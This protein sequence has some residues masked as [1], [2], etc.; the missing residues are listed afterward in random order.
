MLDPLKSQCEVTVNRQCPVCPTTWCLSH[1][2]GLKLLSAFTGMNVICSLMFLLLQVPFSLWSP[3]R[4]GV[5]VTVGD[6]C[7]PR[8]AFM[9]CC[10]PLHHCLCALQGVSGISS[11]VQA[12]VCPCGT[13]ISANSHKLPNRSLQ[14]QMPRDAKWS[15]VG[16]MKLWLLRFVLQRQQAD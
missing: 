2:S 12:G 6:S 8:P 11:S 15:A 10:F 16:K 7:K 14:Y 9:T 5:T 1:S 13:S 3:T 4:K